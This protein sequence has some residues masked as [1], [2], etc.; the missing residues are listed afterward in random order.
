[1]RPKHQ[2]I[3]AVKSSV[4]LKNFFFKFEQSKG[5]KISTKSKSNEIKS[6]IINGLSEVLQVSL[7]CFH[8]NLLNFFHLL[9]S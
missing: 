9:I 8:S 5:L 1:M 2:L 4:K 6:D 3:S 7:I